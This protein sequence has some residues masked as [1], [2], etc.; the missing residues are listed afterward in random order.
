LFVIIKKGHPKCDLGN[1]PISSRSLVVH[2]EKYGE[3]IGDQVSLMEE[4]DTDNSTIDNDGINR[5]IQDT[6]APMDDNFDDIHDVSLIENAQKPIYKSSRINLLFVIL[7][8]VNLKVLN[9]LS[10]TCL[11]QILRYVI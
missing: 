1:V 3:N 6:F 11:T 4:Y 8:V 2:T 7:L 10:N 9:G 5:L